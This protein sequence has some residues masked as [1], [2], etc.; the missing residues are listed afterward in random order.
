MP[1]SEKI[2]VEGVKFRWSV[3][4]Q[5]S[6]S[7]S[8]GAVG[9]AILI[10]TIEPSRRELLVEFTGEP[11]G[12]RC[13]ISHQRFRVPNRRLVE[14]IQSAIRAGWDPDSRGKRFK[15]DAGPVNPN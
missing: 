10:E 3:Y 1:T 6:W 9:L 13:M 5:P 12:H 8:R 11:G 15:F 14:C 7:A 2:Q 4:R